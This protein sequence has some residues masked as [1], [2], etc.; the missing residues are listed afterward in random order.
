M[1][2]SRVKV[3]QKIDAER[4]YQDNMSWNH[5]GSPTIEAELLMLHEYLG[6]ARTAWTDN[7]DNEP[8]LHM[9]RKI[10]GIAVRCLENHG[11]PERY[12]T[13]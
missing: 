8:A 12:L 10:A 9:I 13:K 3:Y 11:C 6:R 5:A 1:S 7:T 2:E 4:A